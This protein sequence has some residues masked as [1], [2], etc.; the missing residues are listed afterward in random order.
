[1]DGPALWDR[2]V[3]FA[4]LLA[5]IVTAW[6]GLRIWSSRRRED[7]AS[8]PTI[9]VNHGRPL[10]R[11]K[12][13]PV[14]CN[15]TLDAPHEAIWRI[16]GA[17]IVRPLWGATISR[18]GEM[19]RNNFNEP[20]LYEALGWRR[21]VRFDPAVSSGLLLI[22]PGAP[23]TVRITFTISMRAEPSAKSRFATRIRISA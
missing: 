15:F 11:Y 23:S 3:N 14:Q 5:L 7:A 13:D 22:D 1:M 10:S 16:E 9:T 2:L 4:S 6:T 20:Y 18:A 17:R 21:S 12:G 8:R 19:T